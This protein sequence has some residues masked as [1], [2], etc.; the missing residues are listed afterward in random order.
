MPGRALGV[1]GGGHAGTSPG[2][3]RRWGMP[4]RAA[5][6]AEVGTYDGTVHKEPLAAEAGIYDGTVHTKNHWQT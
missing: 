5:L 2:C 1:A 6:A 4:G 3:G